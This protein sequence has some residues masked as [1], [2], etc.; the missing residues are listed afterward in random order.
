MAAGDQYRIR[1][2]EKI[3]GSSART[4]FDVTL[5]GAQ[6]QAFELGPRI[7]TEG[8]EIGVVKTAGTDRSIGWSI[9]QRTP[10]AIDTSSI[11]TA[12]AAVQADTDNIQ[13]RLPAALVS[14][15]IDASVGA[16]A[17]NTFTASAVAADAVTEIQSGLATAA[18]LATAAGYIDTEVAAIKAKT[19]NLPSDPADAS[20]IAASHASIAASIAALPSASAVAVLAATIHTG[21]SVARALRIVGAAVAGKLTGS[22]FR[23]LDDSGDAITGT[24]DDDG[25]RTAASYGA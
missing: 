21:W 4:V 13:S 2:Y 12:I 15:R 7:L 22:T 6:S 17:A 19:D 10:D 25:N 14:G 5:G 23:Y 20:D 11:L 8:W 1:L 9:R 3:N 18:E 16:M 24:S